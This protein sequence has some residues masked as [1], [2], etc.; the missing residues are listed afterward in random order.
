MDAFLTG[1][2]HSREIPVRSEAGDAATTDQLLI[3][4]V[5]SPPPLA[6]GLVSAAGPWACQVACCWRSTSPFIRPSVAFL[7]TLAYEALDLLPTPDARADRASDF[8]AP[9]LGTN[10]GILGNGGPPGD[11]RRYAATDGEHWRIRRYH[12]RKKETGRWCPR[13][14]ETDKHPFVVFVDPLR[15]IKK[16]TVLTSSQSLL[17]VFSTPNVQL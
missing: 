10:L 5:Y 6:L 16:V 1:A 4:I 8:F 14:G 9:P 15:R 3:G 2:I 12:Q 17:F 13:A 7:V 11:T